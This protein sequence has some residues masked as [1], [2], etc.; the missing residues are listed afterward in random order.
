MIIRALFLVT[1]LLAGLAGWNIAVAQEE[2]PTVRAAPERDEGLG[3]YNRLV[4]RGAT[5]I[6]GTGAPPYGPVDI[7]IEGNRITEVRVVGYPHL[8][9]D[10]DARP[11][12]GDYE[13]DASGMYVLPGFINAH[14]HISNPGQGNFGDPS[15][16]EYVYK[17]WL[18]HGITTI[19]DVGSGSGFEWTLNEK[20]RS[21]RNEITAP[22]IIVHNGFR[23]SMT[24]DEAVEWVQDIEKDGADGIKFFGAPPDVMRAAV[25]EANR[26]GLKTTMHHAQLAVTRWN[27]LDSA[28][29][30][31]TSMEHW[32][33]LPEALFE[34]KIIQD[35]PVDY[36]YMDEPLETGRQ[37]LVGQMERGDG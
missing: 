5:L 13:I 35:Y 36:N 15:P 1:T 17:L 20:A 26:L 10:P 29:A 14:G 31:M 34:D 18:A 9:I 32:Y 28:R 33:G 30:G 37:T 8:P 19:R 27:V 16:A 7:V 11:E 24:V 4:I 25:A 2:G 21:Q 3:P 23:G 12:A 6:D 22:R